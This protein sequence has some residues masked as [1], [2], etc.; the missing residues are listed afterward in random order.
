MDLNPK[1]LR[2]IAEQVKA[3]EAEEE[4][5]RRDEWDRDAPERRRKREAEAEQA[6]QVILEAAARD[7]ELAAREGKRNCCAVT[8]K[9]RQHN[10]PHFGQHRDCRDAPASHLDYVFCI[11][12]PFRHY[13]GMPE[14]HAKKKGRT[15]ERSGPRELDAVRS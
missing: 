6:F 7:I 4:R 1:R 12:A 9:S 8:G 10:V 14:P 11:N 15:S 13:P 2:S 5:H 3:R